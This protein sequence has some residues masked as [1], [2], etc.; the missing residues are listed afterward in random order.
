MGS[1]YFKIWMHIVFGT[2]ER[3][4]LIDDEWRARLHDYLGGCIRT[5]KGVSEAI[6]GTRDHVHILASLRP[7]HS[8][9]DFMR[10]IKAVSS[11]W[12]HEEIGSA[13]FG[14]QE[15]YG[16]FSVSESNVGAVR[17]YVQNQEEHHRVRTFDEEWATLLAKHRI[18][19]K[20]FDTRG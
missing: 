7:V 20:P 6:G 3:R 5:A 18:E 1:T 4:P 13:G 11:L 2:K 14:W 8:L 15:G 10:E 17:R 9:S 12:V 16:A 19:L